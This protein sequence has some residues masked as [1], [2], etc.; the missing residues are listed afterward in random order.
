MFNLDASIR[1]HRAP[2]PSVPSRIG[3]I[4]FSVP[5]PL[6]RWLAAFPVLF[7]LPPTQ[8]AYAPPAVSRPRRPRIRARLT[9]CRRACAARS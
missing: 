4:A 2:L 6:R 9:N 5:P 3:A 7:L 1:I 8:Q